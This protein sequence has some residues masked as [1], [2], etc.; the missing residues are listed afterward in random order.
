[1]I[2]LQHGVYNKQFILLYNKKNIKT[3]ETFFGE[4][5]TQLNNYNKLFIDETFYHEDK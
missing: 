2:C 3:L 1:M 4:N 5:K